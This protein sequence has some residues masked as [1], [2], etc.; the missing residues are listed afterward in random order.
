MEGEPPFRNDSEVALLPPALARS[1]HSGSGPG[2]RPDSSLPALHSVS[3]LVKCY[4]SA[5]IP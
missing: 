3:Y 2:L 1:R 5:V 4:F